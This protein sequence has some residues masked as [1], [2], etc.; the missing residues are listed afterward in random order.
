MLTT[1]SL[2]IYVI[3]TAISLTMTYLEGVKKGRGWDVMR[4]MGLA[5]CFIWP[6]LIVVM[7]VV[8][9]AS[10]LKMKLARH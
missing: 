10:G 2:V 1:I 9:S 8:I 5:L 7:L 3:G 4:V 6:A